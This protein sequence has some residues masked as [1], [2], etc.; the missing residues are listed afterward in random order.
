MIAKIFEIYGDDVDAQNALVVMLCGVMTRVRS[1]T[2]S[3]GPLAT[4]SRRMDRKHFR[5]W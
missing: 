1:T 3:A 2:Q 5:R 4:G